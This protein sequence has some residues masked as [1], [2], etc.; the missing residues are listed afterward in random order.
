[1]VPVLTTVLVP[2]FLA[3]SVVALRNRANVLMA[4]SLGNRGENRKG[5]K[6]CHLAFYDMPQGNSP[7]PMKACLLMA[8]RTKTTKDPR[9]SGM[10]RHDD[11]RV[12]GVGALA[13]YLFYL[14]DVMVCGAIEA[15]G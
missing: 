12:C 14:F 11:F 15:V 6:L 5:S 4:H 2:I 1:M 7:S 10:F 13:Q 8:P 3:V 9:A